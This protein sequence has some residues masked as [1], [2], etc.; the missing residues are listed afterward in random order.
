MAIKTKGTHLYII[1]PADS[2]VLRVACVTQISGITAARDQV[3][4]SCLEDLA[5]SY[6]AGM[7]TP[8][9]ATFGLNFDT[10][11]ASHTRLH[12]LYVAGTNL[13]W[14]I[15]FGDGTAP[16][17]VDSA[18]E[19][20]TPTTRSWIL[21][22]GYISDYPFDAQLSDVWRSNVTV[23]VSGYPQVLAKSS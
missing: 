17:T 15:G 4:V 8:G 6:E 2:S 5:R 12:E 9:A 3:E 23:Q 7:I 13:E 10:G 16:P 18:D 1:D 21:F 20:D 19:F 14:A 11:E 22:E